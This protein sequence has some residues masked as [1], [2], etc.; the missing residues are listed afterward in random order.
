MKKQY[1]IESPH[2]KEECLRALDETMAMG[3]AVLSK[4]KWGCATGDHTGWAMVEAMDKDEAKGIVPKVSRKKSRI[5]EVSEVS[6]EEIRSYH[7]M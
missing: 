5:V 7:E 4:F 1:L 6:P 2:T 3:P